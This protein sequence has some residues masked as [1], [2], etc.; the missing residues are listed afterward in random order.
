MSRLNCSLLVCLLSLAAAQPLLAQPGGRDRD[1]GPNPRDNGPASPRLVQNRP[2]WKLGVEGEDLDVGVRL[3]H[4]YFPT[5]ASRAG[6]EVNDIIVS[7]NGFQVGVVNGRVFDI[8]EE[9]QRRADARGYVTFLVW[10]HRDRTLVNRTV[11]L[12]RNLEVGRPTRS[13]RIAGTISSRERFV[14]PQGAVLDIHL[15]EVNRDGRYSSPVADQVVSAP[16]GLPAN[17]D[18]EFDRDDIDPNR[19]YVLEAHVYIRG[20]LQY[21]TTRPVLAVQRGNVVA[22]NLDVPVERARSIGVFDAPLPGQPR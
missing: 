20:R 12:E 6:L 10:N 11:R 14:I 3:T 15:L 21:T 13:A 17:F 1:F 19:D 2:N 8:A 7:V 22:R 5:P 9:F 4:V 18:L 16:N